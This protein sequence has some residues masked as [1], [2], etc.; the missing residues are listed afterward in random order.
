MNI[1]NIQESV[2]YKKK[3][4]FKNRL[5]QISTYFVLVNHMPRFV[6][7]TKYYEQ[8]FEFKITCIHTGRSLKKC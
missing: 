7:P 8:S 1:Y 5:S 3:I 6:T 4:A 2:N